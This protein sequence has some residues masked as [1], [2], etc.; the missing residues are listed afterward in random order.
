MPLSI[1]EAMAAGVPIAAT[2][3]GDVREMLCE[4]NRDFVVERDNGM[5]ASAITRLLDEP[6]RA[7]RIGAANAHR[8]RECY[9][10]S[11]MFSTYHE[12]FDGKLLRAE[13][14]G[15]VCG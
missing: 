12:L 6:G 5:L 8:A 4:Q 15:R 1:L 2:D 7:R 10:Q 14:L 3:V 11:K 9:S 13:Q